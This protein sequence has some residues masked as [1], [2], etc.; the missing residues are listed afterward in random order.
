MLWQLNWHLPTLGLLPS[1]ESCW[2]KK[3]YFVQKLSSHQLWISSSSSLS[4]IN[5]SIGFV[6]LW[7]F[8]EIK[9]PLVTQATLSHVSSSLIPLGLHLS[10]H[11][12]LCIGCFRTGLAALCKGSI[13]PQT[14]WKIPHPSHH[15]FY[16]KPNCITEHRSDSKTPMRGF[17]ISSDLR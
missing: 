7:N 16:L 2:G 4:G 3:N 15:S 10:E 1:W 12:W 13:I 11:S 8:S 9:A 17:Q 14:L 6:F 5:C